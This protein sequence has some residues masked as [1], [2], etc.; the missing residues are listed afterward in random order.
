MSAAT[1]DVLED[2]N[3]TLQEKSDEQDVEEEPTQRYC[4]KVPLL[5]PHTASC[6]AL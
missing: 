4:I 6:P 1:V 2:D 3:N 5:L